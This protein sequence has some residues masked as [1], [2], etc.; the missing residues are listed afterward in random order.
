MILNNQ[1][2]NVIEKLR[3]IFVSLSIS[4]IVKVGGDTL[5]KYEFK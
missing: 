4:G 1:A 3:L 2:A 5:Y